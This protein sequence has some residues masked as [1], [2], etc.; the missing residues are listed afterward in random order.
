MGSLV[1]VSASGPVH[2]RLLSFG[3]S[4]RKSGLHTLGARLKE[5]TF[6]Q[7][8]QNRFTVVTGTLNI[9]SLQFA[10]LLTSW[11]SGVAVGVIL[12]EQMPQPTKH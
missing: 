8:K 9:A 6:F 12:V 1:P 10:C 2:V 5:I 4:P 11:V 7:V 3:V